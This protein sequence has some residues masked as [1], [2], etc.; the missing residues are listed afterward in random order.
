ML[1][2]K[3]LNVILPQ[4]GFIHLLGKWSLQRQNL[5]SGNSLLHTKLNA[6]DARKHPDIETLL[7]L[8]MRAVPEQILASCRKKNIAHGLAQSF[9]TGFVI[10]KIAD[11]FDSSFLPLSF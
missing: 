10:F 1:R 6:L 11:A 9:R 5:L 2:H 3:T 7:Q 4:H 8:L